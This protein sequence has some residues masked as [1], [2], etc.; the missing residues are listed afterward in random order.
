MAAPARAGWAGEMAMLPSL[1]LGGPA[2]AGNLGSVEARAEAACGGP[3]LHLG[4][5]GVSVRGLSR[6]QSLD[7]R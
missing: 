6:Q 3:G 4:A 7:L 1:P 2:I 5:M